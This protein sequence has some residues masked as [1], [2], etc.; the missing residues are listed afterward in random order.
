MLLVKVLLLTI[1]I[2]TM[3]NERELTK[4]FALEAI[5]FRFV[6]HPVP[7]Y[8][9]VASLFD[10]Q[11]G[12]KRIE[13]EDLVDQGI[14]IDNSDFKR[15][16]SDVCTRLRNFITNHIKSVVESDSDDCEDKMNRVSLKTIRKNNNYVA[17]KTAKHFD[18]AVIAYQATEAK[19]PESVLATNCFIVYLDI[20]KL[21][22]DRTEP[23]DGLDW[24]KIYT[25]I[26]P[27]PTAPAPVT[28][29]STS[30]DI[31]RLVDAMQQQYKDAHDLKEETLVV[32]DATS[33]KGVP[34]E[35][36]T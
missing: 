23:I 30:N 10:A 12:D 11:F 5:I 22:P 3:S 18:S 16:P 26:Q 20:T 33:G 27:T 14:I 9:Y 1:F 28:G 17:F 6:P 24:T 8:N 13:Q 31:D 7:Y 21:Y 25:T 32:Y 35:C 4:K 15:Y 2:I 29:A 19:R 34:K 36:I